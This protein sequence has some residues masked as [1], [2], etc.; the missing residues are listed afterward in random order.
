MIRLRLDGDD[1]G[2]QIVVRG[3]FLQAETPGLE[4]LVPATESQ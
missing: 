3:V 4:R 2:G 1:A